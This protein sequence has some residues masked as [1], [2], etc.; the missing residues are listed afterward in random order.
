MEIKDIFRQRKKRWNRIITVRRNI[1]EEVECPKCHGLQ[2]LGALK[3]NYYVCSSCGHYFPLKAH[4]RISMICDKGSF[5]ELY[6]KLK[7]GNP[8]DFPD[9]EDKIE[10]CCEKSGIN[11]AVVTGTCKIEGK[12]TAIAVL[13]SSFLMGSM[14]TVVGEKIAKITEYA[15]KKKLPLIIFSASGGARMQEG[16]FSLMQM[17]KTSAAI[18]QF[19]S[20]GGLYISCMTHPTTGGVS[21]SFASLGDIIIAEPGA[22][23]GFAGPRVIKQT[24]GEELPEG[25]QRSEFLLEHG[26]LDMIV[27]RSNLRNM[28]STLLTMNVGR[29]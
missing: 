9:Y 12:R 2:N 5:K 17:A 21:A 13:D 6:G 7:A 1:N 18:E 19:K 8:L 24:I 23:L 10:A 14:G 28:L 15:G 26:M 25:F 16:L 29:K 11:E 20:N 27:E 3:N 4:R 22:L